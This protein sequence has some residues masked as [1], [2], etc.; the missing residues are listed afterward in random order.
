MSNHY[1]RGAVLLCSALAFCF[2]VAL[3]LQFSMH[4]DLNSDGGH[5]RF[6]HHHRPV[7]RPSWWWLWVNNAIA[8]PNLPITSLGQCILTFNFSI[9]DQGFAASACNAPSDGFSEFSNPWGSAW[10]Y[11]YIDQKVPSSGATGSISGY[12]WAVSLGQNESYPQFARDAL[13]SPPIYV[14]STFRLLVLRHYVSTEIDQDVCKLAVQ[15]E[16]DT[17]NLISLAPLMVDYNTGAGPC[18]SSDASGTWSG[19]P[20]RSNVSDWHTSYFDLAPFAGINIRVAL[21]FWSDGVVND[22]A[23]W[24]VESI[25]MC[26]EGN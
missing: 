4:H 24:G 25:R 5:H 23:G 21:M 7:H 10:Q 1:Y 8:P 6:R 3:V 14:D 22:F 9:N 20:F 12:G 26:A 11:G 18:C 19:D 2:F 15:R 13:F 16:N 17:A